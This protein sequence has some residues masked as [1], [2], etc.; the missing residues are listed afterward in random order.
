MGRGEGPQ[1]YVKVYQCLSEAELPYFLEGGQ[2]VNVWADVFADREP[3]LLDHRPFTSKDCDLWI[4]DE[5]FKVLR[6]GRLNLGTMTESESPLGGQLGVIKLEGEPEKVVDLLQGVFGI[7]PGQIDKVYKRSMPINGIRI[8][9]PIFLFKGKCHNLLGLDQAI[10]QDEKHLRMMSLIV[11]AYLLY[12]LRKVHEGERTERNLLAE[13]KLLKQIGK[14]GV[15]K[16][17]LRKIGVSI[18]DL[19]PLKALRD[20]TLEKLERFAN[21]KLPRVDATR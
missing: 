17:A 5:T 16:Q 20:S 9:D 13:I 15:V 19:I 4:G 12:F 1:A 6:E 21:S 3:D 7:P 2:A 8:L 18:D 11:P 14:E 10:R